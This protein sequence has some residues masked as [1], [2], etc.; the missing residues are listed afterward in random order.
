AYSTLPSRFVNHFL[1]AFC[2]PVETKRRCLN[3]SQ[4][5]LR[6]LMT[7]AANYSD[8]SEPFKIFFR[9]P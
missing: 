5:T 8:L 6:Q 7:T 3:F 9:R 4:I 2:S 1:A